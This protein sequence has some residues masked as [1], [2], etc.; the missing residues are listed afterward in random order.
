MKDNR[1]PGQS[2]L[3][4]LW[5]NYAEFSVSKEPT[6]NPDQILTQGAINSILQEFHGVSSVK[7]IEEGDNKILEVKNSDGKVFTYP[8]P[9]SITITSFT[10]RQ[11]TQADRNKGCALPLNTWVY[12]ILLSNG[13]EYIAPI[14]KYIG[15]S[16]EAIIVDVLENAIYAELKISNRNSIVSLGIFDDGLSAD[17][18]ISKDTEGISFEKKYDGLSANVVLQ[19]SDKFI[20]FSLL[21]SKEYFN[22]VKEDQVDETTMY[23]IKGS[24]YFYFGLYKMGGA[25]GSI[26]LDNYYTKQQID[27]KLKDYVTKDYL[28]N[29]LDKNTINWLNI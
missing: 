28:R 15:N 1:K 6:E 9:A 2:Q 17:L 11:I 19:N 26:D 23:F 24:K 5:V 18:N 10:K 3:D 29:E 22:L 21:T 4:Y 8:L 27:N 25:S 7:V 13:N 20:K 16:S 12:A 14:D